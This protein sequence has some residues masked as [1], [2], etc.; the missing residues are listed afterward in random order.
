M[1]APIVAMM[2]LT[3]HIQRRLFPREYSSLSGVIAFIVSTYLGRSPPPEVS[4]VATS[5]KIMMATWMV[6]MLFLINFIQTDITSSRTVPEYSS[7]IRNTAEFVARVRSGTKRLCVNAATSHVIRRVTKVAAMIS[8]L[9]S[10]NKVLEQCGQGCTTDRFW[11]DCAPKIRNGT[12]VGIIMSSSVTS[13]LADRNELVAGADTILTS[14]MLSPAHGSFPLRYQHRRL[15]TA[16]L[17]SGL[18]EAHAT[19]HT[20]QRKVNAISVD[21]PFSDY[22]LVYVAGCGLSSLLL[23]V[24]IAYHRFIRMNRLNGI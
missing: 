6:G 12:H 15:V 21:V 20:R 16:L 23:A 9:D 8:H 7:E 3:A 10:L 14:M 2:L 5:S 13:G 18:F 24:E 1:L 4:S 19:S 22:L 17:E 11:R